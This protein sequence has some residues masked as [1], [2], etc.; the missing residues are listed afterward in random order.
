MLAQYLQEL[1]GFTSVF[2][3]A[4]PNEL[5]LCVDENA[6]LMPQVARLGTQA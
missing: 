5:C 6:R 2:N 3:L 1:K 4:D